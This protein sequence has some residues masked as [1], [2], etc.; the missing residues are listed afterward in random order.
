MAFL[1]AFKKAVCVVEEGE[2][3][4]SFIQSTGRHN[5][6]TKSVQCSALSLQSVDDIH[7]SDSLSL[8]MF[9]VCDSIANDVLKENLENTS[10]LFVNETRDSLYSS[11][12]S[13]SANCWFGDA[14]DVVT[15]NLSMTLSTSFAK[16]LSS[17]SSS[18]HDC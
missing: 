13:Q 11:T 5:L 10:C 15:K 12:T 3:L 1:V 7:G 14:L 18:R 17:F 9:C 8:C 4:Q 6:T 2:P 16:T